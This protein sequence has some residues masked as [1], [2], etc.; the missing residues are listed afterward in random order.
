[1]TDIN[2][3]LSELI[4]QAEQKA[5]DEWNLEHD[6]G[7][8]DGLPTDEILLE[9]LIRRGYFTR[10]SSIAGPDHH[11]PGRMIYVDRYTHTYAVERNG[12]VVV[13]PY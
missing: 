5:V 8:V 10:D 12:N 9:V 2:I 13:V 3:P 1:M 4:A 6:P 11:C 7:F